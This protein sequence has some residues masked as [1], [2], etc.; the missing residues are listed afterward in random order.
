MKTIADNQPP[1]PNFEDGVRAH[2]V[3]D[4]IERASASRTWLAVQQ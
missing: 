1:A 4:A 2:R 3:L